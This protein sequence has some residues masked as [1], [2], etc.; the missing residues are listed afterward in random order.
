MAMKNSYPT[1]LINEYIKYSNLKINRKGYS[2]SDIFKDYWEPFLRDKPHLK[3][4]DS[5]FEN[6]SRTLKCQTPE[7]GYNFYECPNCDNF[8][9]S[10]SI[11][12][13]RFCNTC[14][15]KYAEAR[16]AFASKSLIDCTHRHITFQDVLDSEKK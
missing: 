7:L 15:L 4:R 16:S 6:V 10:F 5:V 8:Y 14:G 2:I 3:I 12:K 1:L 9:I 11:C 13:S